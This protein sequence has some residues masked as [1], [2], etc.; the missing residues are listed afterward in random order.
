MYHRLLF[1]SFSWLISSCLDDTFLSLC[2]PV[3][4]EELRAGQT[5][6]GSRPVALSARL[7]N[8][9]YMPSLS[10]PS[11]QTLPHPSLE[12]REILSV[13]ANGLDQ[14][15]IAILLQP[16]TTAQPARGSGL[17]ASVSLIL[18]NLCSRRGVSRSS[19]TI[20]FLILLP[21][22]QQIWGTHQL[23]MLG[24][25][26]F[27]YWIQC[28]KISWS[29]MLVLAVDFFS[30]AVW[31]V[32]RVWWKTDE[33]FKQGYKSRNCVKPIF[34]IVKTAQYLARRYKNN[35]LCSTVT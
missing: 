8:P 13:T 2:G 32:R 17:S 34:K 27:S 15:L 28:N 23:C 25:F 4:G 3:A 22:N 29:M 9:S 5:I 16:R 35:L 20:L 10:T 7:L 18:F 14:F 24:I 21:F 30:E 12:G 19:I 6:R 1:K 11:P 33:D 26:Y 31:H